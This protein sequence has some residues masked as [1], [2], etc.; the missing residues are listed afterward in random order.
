MDGV[1]LNGW[2]AQCL[3]NFLRR[4][5]HVYRQDVV[6]AAHGF[7]AVDDVRE[8]CGAV[9]RRPSGANTVL[10]RT[11]PSHGVCSTDLSRE[12]A[13]YRNLPVGPS[14]ETISLGFPGDVPTDV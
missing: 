7:C 11:I 8:D 3:R 5:A 4:R 12:P 1:D 10:R 9:Q 14:V 13:R 6:R 2:R